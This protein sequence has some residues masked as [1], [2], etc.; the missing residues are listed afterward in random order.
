[1]FYGI[2]DRANIASME[3]VGLRIQT[4]LGFGGQG[5]KK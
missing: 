3:K 4:R 5:V 1:M 2:T